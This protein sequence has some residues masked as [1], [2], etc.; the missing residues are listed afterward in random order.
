MIFKKIDMSLGKEK[1][2]Q[3][4]PNANGTIVDNFRE[5]FFLWEASSHD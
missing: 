3:S 5:I 4:N 2:K 1:E